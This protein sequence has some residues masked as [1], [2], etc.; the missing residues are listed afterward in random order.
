MKLFSV[1]IDSEQ[2]Y[3]CGQELPRGIHDMVRIHYAT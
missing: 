3:I 2:K 1:M